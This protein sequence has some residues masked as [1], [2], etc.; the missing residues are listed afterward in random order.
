MGAALMSMPPLP[1]GFVLDDQPAMPPLPDGFVLAQDA[2]AAPVAAAPRSFVD[3]L[4]DT[5]PA[6]M[7]KSI[8]SGVTLPGDVYSGKAQLP[9]SGAVP[10]SVEFGSP[11]SAGARVADLS[12]LATPMPTAMRGGEGVL[13]VPAAAARK[14]APVPTREALKEASEQGYTLARGSGVEI[15]PIA[16]GILGERIKSSLVNDGF[17]D[18]LAPKT[19]RLAEELGKPAGPTATIADIEAV[20]RALGKA[21]ADPA[22]KGA[23]GRAI[24]AVD[25]YLTHLSPEQVLAGDATAAATALK[26][27]R[28]NFASMKRSEAIAEALAKAERAAGSSGSGAN[29]DNA[30]RQMIKGLRNSDKK[31]RGYSGD[32]L[33]QM[34][35]VIGGTATGNALRSVGKL[36]PTGVVS[37]ALSGGIGFAIGGPKGAVVL[38]SAGLIAKFL[39]DKSTARQVAKLDEMV[40]TRSPLGQS[41]APGARGASAQRSPEYLQALAKMLLASEQ[42]P[43]AARGR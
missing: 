36:A 16:T 19:F 21:A 33:A 32:E 24:G 42:Q 17:R 43:H 40:R 28:G 6:R 12:V 15:D 38:P 14:A 29:I 1:P 8:V 31:S 20:R 7:A 3:K 39:A 2:P 30:T 41:A 23:A 13:S 22:E 25:D 26:E 5:W 18:I 35:R 4:G 37:S 34:D 11:Q 10:G 27:A 9:S